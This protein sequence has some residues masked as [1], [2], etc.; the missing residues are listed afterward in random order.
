[1]VL[2]SLEEGPGVSLG[3]T[4]RVPQLSGKTPVQQACNNWY[5]CNS[6]SY[7]CNTDHLAQLRWLFIRVRKI[8]LGGPSYDGGRVGDG[9]RITQSLFCTHTHTHAW[10]T[11]THT[12][13]HDARIHT[14]AWSTHTHTLTIHAH[15]HVECSL[16]IILN[17]KGHTDCWFPILKQGFLFGVPLSHS[18]LPPSA[19]LSSIAPGHRP[20]GSQ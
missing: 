11:H 17:V 15:T 4:C 18:C 13:T 12:H 1:M 3:P 20:A 14:H 6:I 16:L 10:C 19:P 2:T 5:L 7:N 8:R 9:M